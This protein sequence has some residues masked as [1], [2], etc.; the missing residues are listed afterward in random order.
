MTPLGHDAIGH[1]ALWVAEGG[2]NPPGLGHRT[3]TARLRQ[4]ACW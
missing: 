1:D 2:L 3:A 4:A